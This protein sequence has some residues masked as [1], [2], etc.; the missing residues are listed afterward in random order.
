MNIKVNHVID[1]KG[2][3][4]P[5]P[6]VKTKKGM[7]Q[8]E[9]GDVMQVEATDQGS[10][11]DMQAWSN[12]NGHQYLGNKQIEGVIHHFIRKASEVE[13]K[14]E[15]IYPHTITNQNLQTKLNAN[16]HMLIVDVREEAEYHFGHIPQAMSIPLGELE[17][18]LDECEKDV[19]LYVICRTGNRSDLAAQL[20]ADKGFTQVRNVL[21]GMHEWSGLIQKEEV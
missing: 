2:M 18:R 15:K 6:I 5:M 10:I 7:D 3:A 19:D 12:K 20:L 8:L 16:E 11:A 1:A 13:V 21:P 14:Q 17:S 4:C 9:S